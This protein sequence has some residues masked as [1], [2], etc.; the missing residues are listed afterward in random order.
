MKNI[1]TVS[2]LYKIKSKRPFEEYVRFMTLLITST[3]HE[4]V[5]FTTEDIKQFI[6][7]RENIHIIILPIEG[8]YSHSFSSDF[9]YTSSN[10][11]DFL[12]IDKIKKL[13]LI[14]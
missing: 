12:S 11:K 9:E 4:M 5:I 8:W 6:P 10:N 2:A 3:S 7:I 1:L 13:N 14:K